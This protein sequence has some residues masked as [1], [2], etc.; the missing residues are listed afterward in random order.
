MKHLFL[1]ILTIIVFSCNPQTKETK[2]LKKAIKKPNILLLLA[3]DLGYGK[4]YWTVIG[5]GGSTE[6]FDK[7]SALVNGKQFDMA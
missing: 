7:Q 5:K 6:D 2:Q 4:Y 3:D 1:Y